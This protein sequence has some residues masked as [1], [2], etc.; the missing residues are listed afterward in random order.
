MVLRKVFVTDP[1]QIYPIHLEHKD[2]AFSVWKQGANKR[3]QIFQGYSPK[4]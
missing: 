2:D 4:K 3:E 1:H